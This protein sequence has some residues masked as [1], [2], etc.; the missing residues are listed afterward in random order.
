MKNYPAYLQDLMREYPQVKN[1]EISGRYLNLDHIGPVLETL[2]GYYTIEKIG[3][4]AMGEPISIVK[5]GTGKTKIFAWSQM[6]GNETTTTK[7]VF[8]L[9]NAFQR[10]EEFPVLKE[11]LEKCQIWIIPMLNPDGGRSYTRANANNVD[12]NRDAQNLEEVESRIL[13]EQFDKF[14]PDFCF[15]LHDQRTIFTAGTAPKPATLSF[16]TP[17][18]EEQRQIFPSRKKSMKLIAAMAADL[19]E[20]L[21]GQIGRYDD[22]FNLNCTGDTFQS[23]EVPTILFEAGHYPG[24]YQR[25]I[26][27]K[28]VFAALVAALHHISSSDYLIF[29]YHDYG[30]LPENQKFFND[31]VLKNVKLSDEEIYDVAIQY[32]EELKNGE[33]IFTPVVEKIGEKM[34]KYG[35]REI[36]CEKEFALQEG[37]DRLAENVVVNKIILN[38]REIDLKPD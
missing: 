32:R 37:E 13:R 30:K 16:L 3:K 15:N 24:D 12:L 18:M 8:D 6:H 29:D 7:A 4:S 35:L 28:Y 36:D 9:L 2:S 1:S 19:K 34:K 5:F 21:P 20:E 22:A 25:E 33:I 17:A 23:Q 10:K 11:I 26:T 31:I 14:S 27:R 38:G